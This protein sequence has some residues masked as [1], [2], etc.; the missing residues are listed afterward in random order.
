MRSLVGPL[1]LRL[2]FSF[3]QS[4]ELGGDLLL[5]G[6]RLVHL[7]GGAD[8][9]ERQLGLGWQMKDALPARWDL[10]RSFHGVRVGGQD[11]GL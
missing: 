11:V 9:V 5:H 8:Q 7:V 6:R 3:G 4:G 1:L 2:V 10:W